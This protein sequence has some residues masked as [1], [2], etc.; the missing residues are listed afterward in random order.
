MTKKLHDKNIL[1]VQTY[2][3]SAKNYQDKFMEMDLYN[4]TFIQFCDLIKVDNAKIFEIASG[5]GNITKYLRSIRPKF[6]IK[7][8]DLAPNMIKLA[9]INNPEVDF[10]R[11]DCRN[12]NEI[13]ESFDAIMCG[14][15]MPYLTKDECSKLIQDCSNLLNT[16]GILYISTMEDD[17]EKSG[18]EATS[19]SG[20]N[21]VYIY[22]HQ[23]D[24]IE[25]QL[26]K[27]GFE[28]VN[29]I[30]KKYPETDGTFLTDMI[31]IVKKK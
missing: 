7:G 3:S 6:Q 26:D 10:K 24:F 20:K 27:S 29:L 2:N 28:I 13:K 9:K 15:C 30:R 23:A 17:Y 19:F 31:F 22:Y 8:I 5:P 25:K 14:F 12:I 1:S 16:N 11:M 21:Q 18:L 4:D